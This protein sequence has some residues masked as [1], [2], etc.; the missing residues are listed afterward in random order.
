MLS[1]RITTACFSFLVSQLA[2][3]QSFD[4]DGQAY[5]QLVLESETLTG[6]VDVNQPL[7]QVLLTRGNSMKIYSAKDIKEVVI[8]GTT[9]Y[10]SHQINGQF[11]LLEVIAWGKIHILYR[12]GI[13]KDEISSKEFSGYFHKRGTHLIELAKKKDFM[14][15]FGND[16]KWMS[17]RIKNQGLNLEEKVDIITIFDYYNQSHPSP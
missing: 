12:S 11:H 16:E 5:G 2:L 10:E 4:A 13:D 3:A 7:N 1:F 15:L 8:D 9:T 17:V 6:K 14:Q